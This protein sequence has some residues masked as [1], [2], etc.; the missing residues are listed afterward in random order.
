MARVPP[1][2]G[3][4]SLVPSPPILHAAPY[5]LPSARMNSSMDIEEMGQ[6]LWS[7]GDGRVG[8]IFTALCCPIEEAKG[9]K[10]S[11][12]C[13]RKQYLDREGRWRGLNGRGA[14]P[15]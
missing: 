14:C 6:A 4:F 3:E 15:N 11:V 2:T 12:S 9:L 5:F 8:K 1:T 13:E 10:L 7:L